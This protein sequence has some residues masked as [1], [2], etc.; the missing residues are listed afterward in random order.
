MRLARFTVLVTAVALMAGG[1]TAGQ[2][3]NPQPAPPSK[4]EIAP[5]P[6]AAAANTLPLD[7]YMLEPAGAN[8]MDVVVD[9]LTI[10]CMQR[11]DQPWPGDA[12]NAFD[13]L[14]DRVNRFGLADEDLAANLGY[15][16]DSPAPPP[17]GPRQRRY[18]DGVAPPVPGLPEGGCAGESARRLGWQP[19]E[20]AWFSDLT[21]RTLQQAYTDP[22]AAAVSARWS[23][24]MSKT[25]FPYAR[26]ADAESDSRWS[27][28]DK[29]TA[30]ERRVAVA[31]VR[32][33]QQ[34]AFSATLG[35]VL[36]EHQQ[37]AVEA[38]RSRL[39]AFRRMADRAVAEAD[40]LRGDHQ[41]P[42][43]G[44]KS[45]LPPGNWRTGH[46]RA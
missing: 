33:K 11:F 25:G 45:A 34:V 35:A 43:P 21:T 15:H 27:G 14:R 6:L 39:D 23:S 7:R 17:A 31:D 24:C 1:C 8:D 16:Y 42:A 29:P 46:A 38:N 44:G 20:F 37:R 40:V 13:L 30:D 41:S 28:S 2:S 19:A 10:A 26:P 3:G 5:P 4:A 12:R 9:R 32:C 22:R 36:A 18:L